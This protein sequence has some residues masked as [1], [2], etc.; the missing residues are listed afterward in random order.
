MTRAAR[1]SYLFIV[2]VIV[3]RARPT[4]DAAAGGALFLFCF[5]QAYFRKRKWLSIIY[6]W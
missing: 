3:W 5:T 1:F 4:G 6:F 2:A